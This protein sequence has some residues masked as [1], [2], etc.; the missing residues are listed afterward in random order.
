MTE[1]ISSS[2]FRKA[3]AAGELVAPAILGVDGG[4]VLEASVGGIRRQLSARNASGQQRRRVFTTLQSADS[5]L[6][7]KAGIVSYSVD[8]SQY[9]PAVAPPRYAQVAARLREA[10]A[11]LR[12]AAQQF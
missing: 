11:A 9:R 3:A 6:R 10:H 2:A 1:L 12:P 5:F 7:D 4:Y 8:A